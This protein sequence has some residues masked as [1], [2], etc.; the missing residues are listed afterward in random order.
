MKRVYS[1]YDI[2]S[3]YLVKGILEYQGI[4]VIIRGEYLVG[5]RG[6]IPVTS[7]TCPSVWRLNDSEYNRAKFIVLEF[8]NSLKEN[9]NFEK[10]QCHGCGEIIEVQFSECWNCGHDRPEW[11]A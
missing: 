4:E 7:D 6:Q 8:E 9:I 2:A 11:I 3:A 10:W 1:S 5:I